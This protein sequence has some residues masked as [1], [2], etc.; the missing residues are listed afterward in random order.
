MHHQCYG[1]ENFSQDYHVIKADCFERFLN[2]S[3]VDE[4]VINSTSA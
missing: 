4:S 1:S 2:L 3:N